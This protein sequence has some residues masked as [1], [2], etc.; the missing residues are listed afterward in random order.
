MPK[1]SWNYRVTRRQVPYGPVFEIREVYY[2]PEGG[3]GWSAEP[4]SPFGEDSLDELKQDFALMMD[5]FVRPVLDITDE[6][7]PYEVTEEEE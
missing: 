1:T 3:L 5:A 6:D 7:N 4:S 2:G